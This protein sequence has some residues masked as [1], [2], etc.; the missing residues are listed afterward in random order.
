M[1]KSLLKIGVASMFICGVLG[2]GSS[3]EADKLPA[4]QPGG[5][6]GGPAET[7]KAPE[8]KGGAGGAAP[9]TDVKP[10]S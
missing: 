2:C 7:P 1:L 10:L 6:K 4:V 3:A 5:A 9:V 8:G